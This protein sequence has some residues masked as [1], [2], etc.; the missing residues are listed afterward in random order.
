MQHI[1]LRREYIRTPEQEIIELVISSWAVPVTVISYDQTYC[2]QWGWQQSRASQH[3]IDEPVDSF[4]NFLPTMDPWEWQLLFDLEILCE[5]QALWNA[6]NTQTFTIASDGLAA[7]GK[8]SFAWVISN[9]HGDILAE[10][11][12][13]VP[14][15]KVTSFCA[16]G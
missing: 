12:G 2:I 15:A 11:R 6:L 14:G 9:A 7:D 8:G 10:C 4:F 13:P 1:R 16:E 3:P 5:E